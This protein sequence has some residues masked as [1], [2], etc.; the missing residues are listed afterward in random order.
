MEFSRDFYLRAADFDMYERVNPRTVLELFQ[1]VAGNHAE[2]IGNGF[3]TL[4][5]KNL[6]WVTARTKF[7]VEKRI[8]R[9]STVKVKTWPLKPQRLIFRREYLIFD[10]NGDIAVRGSTD[11]M[12][13]NSITRSLVSGADIFP[14][15]AKYSE[16]LAIDEKLRK[17]K[18]IEGDIKIS[19]VVPQYTDIDLNGHVNNTRYADFSVNAINP[20][21]RPIKSFQAD[22]HKEVMPGEKLKLTVI[23]NSEKTVVNGENSDGEKKFTCEIVFGE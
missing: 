18:D 15:D 9:Y 16:E 12:I 6:L 21:D 23:S 3:Y 13:I 17:I 20:G 10:E 19:E 11:W 22:Y 7:I 1:D 4:L 2:E 14:K 8:P 5:S